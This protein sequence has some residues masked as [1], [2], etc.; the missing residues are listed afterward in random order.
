MFIQTPV[1]TLDQMMIDLVFVR[2]GRKIIYRPWGYVVKS[3][4]TARSYYAGSKTEVGGKR[5]PSFPLWWKHPNKLIA[6]LMRDDPNDGR[7]WFTTDGRLI[8]NVGPADRQRGQLRNFAMA[9]N[10]SAT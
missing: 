4:A 7:E 3:E 6:D 9:S 1:M 2:D 5:V 10:P 8:I